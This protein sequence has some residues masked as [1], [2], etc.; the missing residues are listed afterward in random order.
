MDMPT[1]KEV[2]ND[3][4]EASPLDIPEEDPQYFEDAPTAYGYAEEMEEAP[5]QKVEVE[6]WMADNADEYDDPHQMVYDAME[7]VGGPGVN[8]IYDP[9][10]WIYDVARDYAPGLDPEYWRDTGEEAMFESHT[11]GV[12]RKKKS[13]NNDFQEVV[14]AIAPHVSG[15][16]ADIVENLWEHTEDWEHLVPP[17]DDDEETARRMNE[18]ASKLANAIYDYHQKSAL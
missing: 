4:L 1:L 3:L 8:W 18:M 16:P 7:A 6:E 12:P 2:F 5:G 14:R 9:T 10:H 15:S 13:P 17:G 11:W